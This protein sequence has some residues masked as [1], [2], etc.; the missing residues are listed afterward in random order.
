MSH[1][2]LVINL[3]II[4][5]IIV[6]VVLF[7]CKGKTLV[8]DLPSHIYIELG[9][10]LNPKSLNNWIILAG[11]LGFNDSDVKNFDTYPDQATQRVLDEWGQREDS[12]VNALICELKEMKRDD[13]VQVLK[14][15]ES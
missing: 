8:R 2:K 11:R 1:L 9:R 12:T 5:L 10:F 6:I 15:W 13:C 14:P 3:Y 7:I 4:V